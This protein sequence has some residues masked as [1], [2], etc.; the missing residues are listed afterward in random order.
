M[1]LPDQLLSDYVVPTLLGRPWITRVWTL[2]EAVLN[3]NPWIQCGTKRLPWRSLIHSIAFISHFGRFNEASNR[4]IALIQM[5]NEIHLDP[6]DREALD[7]SRKQFFKRAR[8]DIITHWS[9]PI[10]LSFGIGLLS[11]LLTPAI[12]SLVVLYV[13]LA[14]CYLYLALYLWAIVNCNLLAHLS[15]NRVALHPGSIL[16]PLRAIVQE[17]RRRR[18]L[19]PIDRIRGAIEVL[20]QLGVDIQGPITTD[21]FATISTELTVKWLEGCKSLNLLLCCS[22][23]GLQGQPSWVPNWCLFEEDSWLDP[24]YLS[25]TP[26]D[27]RSDRYKVSSELRDPN[28]LTHRLRRWFAS[29]TNSNMTGY[30]LGTAIRPLGTGSNGGDWPTSGMCTPMSRPVWSLRDNHRLALLGKQVGH[31]T[32]VSQDFQKTGEAFDERELPLHIHNMENIRTLRSREHNDRPPFPAKPAWRHIPGH[33]IFDRDTSQSQDSLRK[34]LFSKFGRWHGLIWWF[35]DRP[36]QDIISKLNRYPSL[37]KYHIQ[38]TNTFAKQQRVLAEASGGS[39][40]VRYSNCPRGTQVGDRIFIISG[41]ALPLVL[42][43]TQD[44]GVYQLIGF[45]EV[46][47]A[48]LMLGKV[49]W[50]V[51]EDNSL[52][53]VIVR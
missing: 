19:E 47:S 51:L 16:N 24:K 9:M 3:P 45:A 27:L 1:Y 32:W 37:S 33:Y 50:R 12:G 41:I 30:Q 28:T 8:P 44:I 36:A 39:F 17:I 13:L 43:E 20:N 26:M 25:F 14:I 53:E 40:G 35:L 31:I 21:N 4:W 18:C 46:R 49:W 5:W 2:Q 52:H 10:F 23:Q 15:T 42:R 7:E 48:E 6:N 29:V 38:L 11:I 34:L 22:N